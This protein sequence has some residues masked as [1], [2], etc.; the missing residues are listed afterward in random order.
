MLYLVHTFLAHVQVAASAE[1]QD[2]EAYIEKSQGSV[3]PAAR[4]IGVLGGG[5]LGRMMALAAVRL[6]LSDAS[7]CAIASCSAGIWAPAAS[8][9]AKD[10]ATAPQLASSPNALSL[11]KQKHLQANL[12]V[13]L[14]V[15]DPAEDAPAAVAAHHT[16]GSFADASAIEAFV[17]DRH[18]D[19]LTVE[20]EHVD[21]DAIEA[22]QEKFGVEVQP[23]PWTLRTLQARF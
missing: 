19:V 15:L 13:H 5:Q 4:N 3:D 11:E 7:V 6:L 12:G 21:V 17:Q 22:V 14:D 16:R 23:S 2:V 9:H 1:A 20:I 18:I 8:H 10:T